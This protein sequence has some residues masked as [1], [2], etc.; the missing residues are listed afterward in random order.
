MPRILVSLM[1]GTQYVFQHNWECLGPAGAEA[2]EPCLTR[3][4][5]SFWS[6]LVYL[7]FKHSRQTHGPQRKYHSQELKHAQDLR[8]PEYQDTRSL[9][10]PESQDHRESWILS[11]SN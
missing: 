8:I 3:S 7:G 11:S 2:Q 10:N 6:A 1:S 4:S 5:S 9:V